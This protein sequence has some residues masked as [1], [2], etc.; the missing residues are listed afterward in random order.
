[1]ITKVETGLVDDDFLHDRFTLKAYFSDVDYYPVKVYKDGRMATF[2]GYGD[3]YIEK[4]LFEG[5]LYK[6]IK[7]LLPK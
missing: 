4:P 7:A 6:E 1:M 3:D 2:S 5:T